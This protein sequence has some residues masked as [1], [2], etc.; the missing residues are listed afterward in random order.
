MGYMYMAKLFSVIQT[1][2]SRSVRKQ[3]AQ[4]RHVSNDGFD[5]SKQGKNTTKDISVQEA[6]GT[7]L[8]KF[9]ALVRVRGKALMVTKCGFS[10]PLM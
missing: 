10:V 3:P 4:R 2:A 5:R 9:Y 6:A 1:G 8:P 7:N